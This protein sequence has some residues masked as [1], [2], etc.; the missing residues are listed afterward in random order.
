MEE[1]E[2]EDEASREIS[3]EVAK[4]FRGFLWRRGSAR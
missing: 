1:D 2:E 3:I 4:H